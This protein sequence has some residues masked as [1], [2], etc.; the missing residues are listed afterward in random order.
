MGC[1]R[2]DGIESVGAKARFW[3]FCIL[4]EYIFNTTTF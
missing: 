2:L 1:M 4:L 3:A